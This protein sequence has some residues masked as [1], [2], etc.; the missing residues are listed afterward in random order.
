MKGQAFSVNVPKYDGY[1]IY[2][3]TPNGGENENSV[4]NI[5]DDLDLFDTR[6][7]KEMAIVEELNEKEINLLKPS[8]LNLETNKYTPYSQ[9]LKDLRIV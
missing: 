5:L 6:E 7:D 9:V 2:C 8:M 4:L 1:R 3:Y